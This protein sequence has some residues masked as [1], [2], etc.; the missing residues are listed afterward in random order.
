MGDFNFIKDPLDRSRPGGD[1][2]NMMNFSSAMQA[3]DL[4]E[5]P[6]KGRNYTWSSMQDDPLLEKLDWIFT[7]AEWTSDFPN[8]MAFPL[9]RLGSDHIPIH[10]QVGTHIPKA[11]LFRVEN[12]WF[13]F[14][15]IMELVTDSWNMAPYK[16][17]SALN[18]NI[19]FKYLRASLKKWS[20]NHSKLHKII[21]N[22]NYTLALLDGIEEQ[23]NLSIMEK[24][25]GKSSKHTLPSSWKQKESTKKIKQR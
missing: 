22:C 19:K 7:S 8:T 11:Q 2:N 17:D 12:Y 20:R 16:Q 14:D 5:I 4:E 25:L 10:I 15:G 3:L 6:L 24:N 1:N 21:D 9:A 13:E 18:I 23:R